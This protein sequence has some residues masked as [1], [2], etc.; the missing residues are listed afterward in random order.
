MK[1]SL[2]LTVLALLLLV[3]T[4]SA[5]T[6]SPYETK[7]HRALTSLVLRSGVE[8][9]FFL[10]SGQV[11]SEMYYVFTE[12]QE[13]GGSYIQQVSTKRAVFYEDVLDGHP[14]VERIECPD[15]AD[16]CVYNDPRVP[17]VFQGSGLDWWYEIHIPPGSVA[18]I[19]DLGVK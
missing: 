11:G 2:L 9:S 17:E 7:Y 8:G 16:Y 15:G 14:Y 1:R 10:A 6:P 19:I 18:S 13:D 5:C 4:L 3:P 12:V